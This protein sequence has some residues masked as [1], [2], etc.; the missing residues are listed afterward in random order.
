MI[1]RINLIEREP[2]KFTYRKVVAIVAVAVGIC[3]LLFGILIFRIHFQ[4]KSMAVIQTKISALET[5]RQSLLKA[6]P[7]KVDTGPYSEVKNQILAT[8][9]WSEL[10]VDIGNRL[11][12]GTYLTSLT[13]AA[14]QKTTVAA[15]T[16]TKK[17]A[18][19]EVKKGGLT[20]SGISKDADEMSDFANKLKASIFVKAVDLKSSVKEDKGFNFVIECDLS[21][22][23][24]FSVDKK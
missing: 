18:K 16:K 24:N 21:N 4:D 1:E 7:T 14:D 12:S 15:D 5:E 11:P 20:L 17:E 9:P 19:V 23:F 13:A 2:F 22:D 10:M 6:A 8:P 3:A